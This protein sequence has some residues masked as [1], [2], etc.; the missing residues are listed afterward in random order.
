M[1]GL[2]ERVDI[3]RINIRALSFFVLLLI[4]APFLLAQTSGTGALAGHVTDPSGAV[5]PGVTVTATSAATGQTRTV[6]T[7]GDG[8]YSIGLLP[9][10]TYIVK[11]E[12][13]GFKA[14]TV[15]SVTVTVTETGTL[16]RALEVGA[17]TQ[18]VTVQANVETVQTSNATVG[19]V[20]GSQA[21]T[22]LPLNTRNYINLLSLSA[23]ASANVEN[24][25]TLGKGSQDVAVNGSNADSN[26]YQ[27]D[28]VSIDAGGGAGGLGENGPRGAIL[29]A[30]GGRQLGLC[31]Q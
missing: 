21:V 29:R 18:E 20:I 1:K 10:G 3:M 14:E 16:D 9:P 2:K 11:F 22:A 25:T 7:G 23:G 27:M 5:I 8:S 17:Q 13:A 24:A 30:S 4:S 28:G 26:N 31:D 12:A 6:T 19:T 15:P